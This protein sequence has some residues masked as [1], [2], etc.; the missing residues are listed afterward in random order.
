MCE[1]DER[2]NDGVRAA[3]AA[4]VVEEHGVDL[5]LVERERADRGD[6]RR[7]PQIVEREPDPEVAEPL[8][9]EAVELRAGARPRRDD[10]QRQSPRLDVSR[11]EELRQ[12]VDQL[13]VVDQPVGDVDSD[14]EVVAGGIP[15]L[16]TAERVRRHGERQRANQRRLLDVGDELRRRD[17]PVGVLAPDERLGGT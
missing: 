11:V 8:H 16:E 10:L 14:V 1:L 9:H 3:A 6:R 7:A 5:H 17:E 15:F 13:G 4:N 12:P 2:P